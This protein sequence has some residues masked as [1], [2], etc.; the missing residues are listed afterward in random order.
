MIPI[1]IFVLATVIFLISE[2]RR[3]GAVSGR[4][5]L[6]AAIGFLGWFIVNTL[7]WVWVLEGESGAIIL[8]P[9]R[10]LPLL[11]T[12]AVLLVLVFARRRMALLGILAAIVVNAIGMLLFVAP[13]PILDQRSGRVL[14]MLPFYLYFFFPG[15]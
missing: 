14:A 11:L 4:N 6:E 5:L 13:G 15:L 2:F 9:I 3:P 7:V 8:N 12:A 1:L 10:L